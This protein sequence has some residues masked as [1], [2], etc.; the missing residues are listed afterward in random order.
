MVNRMPA[1]RGCCHRTVLS[2]TAPGTACQTDGLMHRAARCASTITL[3]VNG[4]SDSEDIR[5]KKKRC[6]PA[7]HGSADRR[8]GR[9]FA[10]NARRKPH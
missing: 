2:L 10:E 1:V 8:P 7:G 6:P 4:D 5:I 3:T 9:F